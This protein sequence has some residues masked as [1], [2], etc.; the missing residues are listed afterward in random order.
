MPLFIG[1]SGATTVL[2]PGYERLRA[3]LGMGRGPVRWLVKPFRNTPGW[4]KRSWC[5]W[6]ATAASLVPAPAESALRK[7]I[8]ADCAIDDWGVTWRRAPG[9]IYFEMADAPLRGATLDDLE[10]YPGRT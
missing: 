4:T 6:A 1:T 3:Y 9:S 5:A 2:G 8:S 10:R 7:D